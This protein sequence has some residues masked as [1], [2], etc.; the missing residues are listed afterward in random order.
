MPVS[1]YFVLHDYPGLLEGGPKRG[2]MGINRKGLYG[3]GSWERKPAAHALAHLSTLLDNRFE[4]AVT[5]QPVH[6]EITAPGSMTEA[7]TEQIRTYRLNH[8]GSA[9]PALVYWLS[10]PM[11]TRCD[12]ARVTLTWPG[13][14][15]TQPVLVDLLDGSV[16]AVPQETRPGL[17]R[18]ERLPLADSPMVVCNRDAVELVL[19]KHASVPPPQW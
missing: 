9:Q 12:P 14:K 13:A 1:I 2:E 15:L 8:K 6:F 5:T 10:A 3:H 17:L 18:F 11:T 16:F 4:S 19:R 7:G